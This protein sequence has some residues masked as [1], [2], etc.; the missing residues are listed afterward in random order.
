MLWR[1]YTFLSFGFFHQKYCSMG[2]EC[3][4]LGVRCWKTGD[5]CWT[6]DASCWIKRFVSDRKTYVI[7]LVGV[8]P[9]MYSYLFFENMEHGW[10]LAGYIALCILGGGLCLVFIRDGLRSKD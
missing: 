9:A 7:C 2:D 5:R 3:W 10:Y 6:F 1:T 8:L 4:M